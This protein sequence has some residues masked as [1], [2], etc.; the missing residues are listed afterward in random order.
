MTRLSRRAVLRGAGVALAL[1][2]FES[3]AGRASAKVSPAPKRYVAIF[4]PNGAPDLW[5]PPAA[6]VGQNWQLSSVLEPL[7]ALKSKTTVLSGLENGS[8]FNADGGSSVQPSHG[9]LPAAWLSCVNAELIR[10]KTG[11]PDANGISVD[12]IIAAHPNFAGTTVV[13]SLQIG[14]STVHSNCDGTPCSWSRSVSWDTETTP[15]YK[16]VDP[17]TLFNQ[18]VGAGPGGPDAGLRRDARRSVLDAV[19]ESAALTRA[20]LSA[21]DKL[22]MDE[23][24]DSVRSVE[25]KVVDGIVSSCPTIPSKPNFPMVLPDGMRQDTGAY[26]KSV[27]FDLM[28]E[29]LALALQ[30]DQTRV[31]TYML[32]DERSEY[33]Y[34]FVQKRHF[35]A[36]TSAPI[37][38]VGNE[39]HGGGQNGSTDDFATIVYW[40]V[41][42]VA[43][44]CQRLAGMPEDNGQSVLDNSVVFLGA[45]M[46]GQDHSTANLPSLLVGG[47]GGALKTDQHLALGHRPLR[48]LHF[49]LMNGVYGLG[50]TDFGVDLTGAP[51]AII[52]QLLTG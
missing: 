3:F 9:R 5:Q 34:D 19:Q 11:V 48:D 4:I 31:A 51:I 32:E 17:T 35:E 15:M 33:V 36:L 26:K 39:W 1:P 49:T 30:C 37:P 2:W 10:Q 43:E 24:V 42:K 44:F 38:G 6:G 46:H 50:V 7:S 13:P 29:L 20:R 41:A 14:L 12:Q 25:K 21:H 22:R 18:L 27:H 8:P 47:G 52:D 40:H 23:F 16:T 45:A 28:N